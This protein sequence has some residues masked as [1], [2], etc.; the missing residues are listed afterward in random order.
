MKRSRETV[1]LLARAIAEIAA[2]QYA[3]ALDC[4]REALA[5]LETGYADS[6]DIRTGD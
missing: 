5:I 6:Q 2:G 1:V 4:V 3:N